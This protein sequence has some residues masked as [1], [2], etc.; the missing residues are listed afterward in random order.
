MV[1]VDRTVLGVRVV[2][3]VRGGLGGLEGL[4]VSDGL[5][6]SGGNWV[7]VVQGVR[8]VWGV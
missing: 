5:G 6:G 3:L 1:L 2:G 8:L 7:R 4:G